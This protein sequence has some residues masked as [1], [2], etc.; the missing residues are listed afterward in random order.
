MVRTAFL[1][2]VEEDKDGHQWLRSER[3]AAMARKAAATVEEEDEVEE[4]EGGGA[5]DKEAL[6]VEVEAKRGGFADRMG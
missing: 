1:S 6:G 3:E 5:M 4:E 2:K